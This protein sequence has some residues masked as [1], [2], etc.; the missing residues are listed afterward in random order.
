MQQCRGRVL[1]DHLT[2]YVASGRDPEQVKNIPAQIRGVR[3]AA[4]RDA[5]DRYLM[6]VPAN[7]VIVQRS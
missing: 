1:A 6:R 3:P 4:V 7:V 2:A 5:F